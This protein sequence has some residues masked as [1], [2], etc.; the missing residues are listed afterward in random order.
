MS[1]GPL[2]Y[3]SCRTHGSWAGQSSISQK[4]PAG[5]H[6]LKSFEDKGIR[7]VLPSG[8][9]KRVAKGGTQLLEKVVLSLQS[10]PQA[11]RWIPYLTFSS[12]DNKS[13]VIRGGLA[14]AA[15]RFPGWEVGLALPSRS[16]AGLNVPSAGL[17]RAVTPVLEPRLGSLSFPV[18]LLGFCNPDLS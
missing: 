18:L 2:S 1:Q 10:A 15:L 9:R 16:G 11:H 17:D 5:G 4:A 13:S 12:L 3:R 7:K 6:I 8:N 14:L